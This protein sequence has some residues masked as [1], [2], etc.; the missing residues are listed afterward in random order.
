MR[1]ID[2]SSFLS[3]YDTLL[4]DMDGVITH[5]ENLLDYAVEVLNAFSHKNVLICTNSVRRTPDIISKRL[6]IQGFAIAPDQIF[7][8]A[9]AAVSYIRKSKGKQKV[10]LVGCGGVQRYFEENG[11]ILSR[12]LSDAAS[13]V[14]GAISADDMNLESY[15]NVVNWHASGGFTMATSEDLTVPST[16]GRLKIGTGFLSSFLRAVSPD[17]YTLVGKPGPFYFSEVL[18]AVS[19]MGGGRAVMIGDTYSADILGANQAG[20][21]ALYITEGKQE[22][23][24]GY[25]TARSFSLSSKVTINDGDC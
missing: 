22:P 11:V 25:G 24:H 7:T 23:S 19:A 2:L 3:R 14:I 5:G 20:V 17:N 21:E 8:G 4:V 13:A 1:T 18:G 9:R 10:W 12:C 16:G 6:S 15:T